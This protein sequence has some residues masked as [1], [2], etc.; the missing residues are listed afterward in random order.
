[1]DDEQIRAVMRSKFLIPAY[2]CP[3]TKVIEELG[4]RNGDV[5]ADIAVLNGNFT[6]YEIKGEEDTFKRLPRQIEGY[7]SI[8]AYS[9]LITCE[10]HIDKA[11]DELPERWGIFQVVNSGK[12]IRLKEL[13]A[14][15]KNKHIDPFSIAQLLWKDEAIEMAEKE[16]HVKLPSRINKREISEILVKSIS[17]AKLTKLTLEVLKSRKNWRTD[18]LLH[19]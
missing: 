5:R 8:F 4:I 10:K 1:M 14:A 7:D 17:A 19:D 16:A 18:L 2:Q 3:H 6:G 13:R 15:K 11:L 9:S 12:T